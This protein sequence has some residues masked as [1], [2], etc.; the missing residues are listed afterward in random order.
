ML[1]GNTFSDLLTCQRAFDR[2][3]T[4]YNVERPHEALDLAP[5]ATRYR[6]SPR[7]FPEAL[8][9]ITYDQ[10]ELVRKVQEGAS[11]PSEASISRS[12]RPSGGIPLHSAQPPA[13]VVLGAMIQ[14]LVDARSRSVL[15]AALAAL[16]YL[17]MY[18]DSVAAFGDAGGSLA[19]LHEFFHHTRHLGFACH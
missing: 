13:M 8:P 18:A 10:G 2:W 7:G 4:V 12:A 16:A 9:P 11:S 3:R 15:V 6:L 19:Y 17:S 5:P 1:Q 14:R